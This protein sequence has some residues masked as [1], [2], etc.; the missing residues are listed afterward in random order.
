MALDYLPAVAKL[1]NAYD[2]I[3]PCPDPVPEPPADDPEPPEQPEPEPPLKLEDFFPSEE[4]LGLTENWKEKEHHDLAV[5]A[6][7]QQLERYGTEMSQYDDKMKAFGY[8]VKR[9]WEHW[10]EFNKYEADHREYI[11]KR[12]IAN[13][14]YG[15]Y[16]PSLCMGGDQFFGPAIRYEKLPD[17][18]VMTGKNEMEKERVCITP[19]TEAYGLLQYE[20]CRSR[21]EAIFKHQEN[22]PGAPALKYVKNDPATQHL[23]AKWSDEVQGKGSGWDREAFQLYHQRM[24]EVIAWR[25]E[26]KDAGYKR[27]TVA[28]ILAVETAGGDGA[29]DSSVSMKDEDETSA[30]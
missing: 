22:H 17:S 12:V 24:R 1:R 29:S 13:W 3:P 23:K 28:R 19:S 9:H 30:S 14:R 8:A 2:N 4:G 21:W 20:N 7:D 18:M 25:K 26:E 10:R 6:Y 16:T 5:E 11:E 27:L 15:S